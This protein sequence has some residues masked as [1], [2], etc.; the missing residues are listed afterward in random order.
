MT[1]VSPK[2]PNGGEVPEALRKHSRYVENI[3]LRRSALE[4]WKQGPNELASFKQNQ[5][6]D[7]T[8]GDSPEG[9]KSLDKVF[10][11]F[12]ELQDLTS[13]TEAPASYDPRCP[14]KDFILWKKSL[15]AQKTKA[16]RFLDAGRQIA[17][18]L[19]AA[20]EAQKKQAE[21]AREEERKKK[22]KEAEKASRA[23]GQRGGQVAPAAGM[24]PVYSMEGVDLEKVSMKSFKASEFTHEAADEPF[25]IRGINVG[26]LEK[27]HEEVATSEEGLLLVRPQEI[28]ELQGR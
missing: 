6:P 19:S 22:Q 11:G 24:P 1:R 25:V 18:D 5:L 13:M 9:I 27:D 23:S 10:P 3:D 7:G 15:S 12:A 20:I 16:E 4:A 8:K 14:K 21:A 26:S 28:A 2:I 17:Q